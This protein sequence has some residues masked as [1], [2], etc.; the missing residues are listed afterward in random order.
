MCFYFLHMFFDELNILAPT[1]PLK[2]YLQESIHYTLYHPQFHTWGVV[3]PAA[4]SGVS[5][6]SP[7]LTLFAQ[8]P[9]ALRGY[10]RSVIC[11]RRKKK[12]A[13]V[14]SRRQEVEDFNRAH[15]VPTEMAIT[16]Q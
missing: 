1:L 12:E 3:G 10:R 13:K 14:H 5:Q 8:A 2:R 16:E 15:C 4:T 6:A 11:P 9:I 7:L